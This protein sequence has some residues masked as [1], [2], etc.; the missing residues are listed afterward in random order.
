MIKTV[1]RVLG[2][3]ATNGIFSL[4]IKS[5]FSPRTLKSKINK[6]IKDIKADKGILI[7]TELYG[8]T[9]CNVCLDFVHK[10]QI[11]LICGYNLPMLL[12]AATINHDSSLAQITAKICDTGKKYIKCVNK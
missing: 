4:V 7:M 1:Q 2:K 9:Q 11:E 8:S 12:K 3:D 6:M 5:N 10:G